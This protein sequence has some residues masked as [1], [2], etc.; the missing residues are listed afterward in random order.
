MLLDASAQHAGRT[1]REVLKLG[2][3]VMG[4]P[5]ARVD[6]MLAVVG[7]DQTEAKRRIGNYSPEC[8]SDSASRMRC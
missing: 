3:I 2:A 8:V 1:G 4:L 7:L 5:D 6:E